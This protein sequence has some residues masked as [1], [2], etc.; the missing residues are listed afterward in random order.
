MYRI[1]ERNEKELCLGAFLVAAP[2]S[3]SGSQTGRV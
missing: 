2:I 3:V 1:G